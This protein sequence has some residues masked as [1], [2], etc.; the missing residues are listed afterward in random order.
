MVKLTEGE[1]LITLMLCDLFKRIEVKSDIDP[2][3]VS[4]AIHRGH[5]WALN[6]QYPG[7]FHGDD[8]DE[9]VVR[10]TGDILTMW[11]VL[12]DAYG[13]LNETG[14]DRFKEAVAPWPNEVLFRGFDGNGEC[15]HMSVASFMINKMDRFAEFKGRDLNAHM[16]TLDMHR[17]MLAVFNLLYPCG[18][19]YGCLTFENLVTIVKEQVHPEN[20]RK[21]A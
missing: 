9:P 2:D 7:I 19:G 15:R 6:W 8:T 10:E 3:F 4:D 1:R 21:V 12:E 5:L 17:R 13:R 18:V 11:S 20:R 16:P 14:R